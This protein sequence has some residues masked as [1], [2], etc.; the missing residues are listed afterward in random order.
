MSNAPGDVDAG[1]LG[2]LAAEQRAAGGL[3]RRAH[4]ADD[5]GDE[6]GVE[7][8]R[9][10]VVEEEQRPGRL[11]EDVADAVVDDVHAGAA[12]P[13]EAGGQLDLGAD[14]VGRRHE[15]RVV[16]RQRAPWPRR[17]R[18]SCRCRA[19]PRRRGC[20]RRPPSAGRRR[21]CP[22]RCRRRRRRRSAARRRAPASRCPG[23]PASRRSGRRPSPA[24]AASRAAARSAPSPVTAS[25][26]PPVV[27]PSAIPA[28]KS[29][30]DSDAAEARSSARQSRQN[31]DLRAGAPPGSRR[32]RRRRCTRRRGRSPAAPP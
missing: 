13:A 20:A 6:V 7:R 12:D 27:T 9:G 15:D 25:T 2:R 29:R 24:Y 3:A 17:R 4:A 10:D 31:R 19:R 32:P 1:H 14:A 5:L 18:R 22:R 21:G 16:H 8:R 23:A 28:G 30:T 26:R 11:H